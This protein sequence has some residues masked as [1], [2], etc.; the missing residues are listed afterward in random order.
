MSICAEFMRT[1]ESLLHTTLIIRSVRNICTSMQVS[2]QPSV[3][4]Q[5]SAKNHAD[6]S[7]ELQ[8]T[9]TSNVRVKKKCDLCDTDFGMD[10][11]IKWAGLIIADLLGFSH[12]HT[13][14]T[15]EFTENGVKTKNITW[16]AGLWV[17][18]CS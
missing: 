3:L 1:P 10:A 2:Y 12:T 15:L 9:V 18:T 11:G 17:E 13:Q 14:R 4:Q 8:L 5:H 7:K 6:R 16:T